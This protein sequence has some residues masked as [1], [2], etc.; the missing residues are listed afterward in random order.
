MRSVH[1]QGGP[2][3]TR[4]RLKF[5]ANRVASNK[6]NYGDGDSAT[7]A[8][9]GHTS[10]PGSS[11]NAHSAYMRTGGGGGGGGGGPSRSSLQQQHHTHRAIVADESPFLA[12]HKGSHS[13]MRNGGSSQVSAKLGSPISR[14]AHSRNTN[15]MMM[16]NGGVP[17]HIA[18]HGSFGIAGNGGPAGGSGGS[19]GSG[20]SKR[21]SRIITVPRYTADEE[22][23]D[24]RAPLLIPRYDR[25][26]RSR[27]RRPQSASLRQLEHNELRRRGWIG[28]FAGCIIAIITV[29]MVVTGTVGFMFATSKPLQDVKVLNMTDV[30]VSQQEI[31]LDLVVQAINPNVIGV[32]IQTMDVNLFAKSSYVRD[33]KDKDKN[34]ERSLLQHGLDASGLPWPSVP[35]KGI[36]EGTD[37]DPNLPDQ[38]DRQTMLLGRIFQFDS[39]L[40][41]DGS[42]FQRHPAISK[43]GLRLAKPGNKTE[44]GGTERWE[45][46]ILHPFELIVRGVL[47]YQLPLSGRVRTASIGGS[48]VV[49]PADDS[50]GLP[51]EVIGD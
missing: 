24:E 41:F 28:R 48:V 9:T 34:K 26:G 8:T 17:L 15:M 25:N 23:D 47:K 10:K 18:G 20:T 27:H 16:H 30:L 42:P 36:D 29:L 12:S 2:S 1:E 7:S 21:S 40:T 45:R 31:M 32:T 14:S 11:R 5:T 37:P 43:G 4:T 50:I 3:A 49:N 6:S 22:G 19:G 39:A 46:V 44:Q 35:R 51:G 33:D 13:P 38:E